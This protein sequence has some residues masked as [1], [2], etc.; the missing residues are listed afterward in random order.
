MNMN[1]RMEELV[2][3][4]REDPQDAFLNYALAM[5]YVAADKQDQ[6]I[7]QLE[8]LRM[9]HPDYLGTYYQLGQLYE[10]QQQKNK[11]MEM[12]EKGMELA[13]K[14]KNTKTWGELNTAYEL[15]D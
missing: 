5:E 4:L 12:Y 10:K 11:A 8:H 2:K 13:K 7:Q 3:M 9:L 14:Q 1:K 15:M 6:A